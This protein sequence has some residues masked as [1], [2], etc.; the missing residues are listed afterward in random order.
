[1][2]VRARQIREGPNVGSYGIL[3]MCVAGRADFQ[4]LDLKLDGFAWRDCTCPFFKVKIRRTHSEDLFIGMSTSQD[5]Y[6]KCCFLL[7]DIYNLEVHL[8][9]IGRDILQFWARRKF[10]HTLL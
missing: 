6:E 4:G 2:I 8:S 1:M 5:Y 7:P 9:G 3:C 10:S